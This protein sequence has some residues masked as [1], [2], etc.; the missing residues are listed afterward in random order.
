MGVW[1]ELERNRPEFP[2]LGEPPPT[3]LSGTSFEWFG[4]VYRKCAVHFGWTPKQV[5]SM[6]VWEIG[7]AL[8]AASEDLEE[9]HEHRARLEAELEQGS[10]TPG[11][12]PLGVKSGNDILAQRVAFASGEGPKPEEPVMAQIQAAQ[13]MRTLRGD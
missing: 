12:S 4:L 9:W 7:S 3:L 6:E 11:Y 1:P 8:G 13:I 2:E 10:D 5:D